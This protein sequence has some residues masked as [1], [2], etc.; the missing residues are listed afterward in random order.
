[1]T[2]YDI[3]T[4]KATTSERETHICT[5]CGRP[6]TAYGQIDDDT[7]YFCDDHK[8]LATPDNLIAALKR[9]NED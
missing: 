8:H 6:C 1:M 2:Q 7:F 3:R 9:L 4:G 5:I